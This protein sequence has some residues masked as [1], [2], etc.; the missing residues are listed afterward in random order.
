MPTKNV[1]VENSVFINENF[2]VGSEMSGGVQA[3]FERV[4]DHGVLP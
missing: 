4:V 2:A 1:L 3:G